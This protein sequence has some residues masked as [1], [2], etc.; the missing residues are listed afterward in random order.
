MDQMKKITKI[1]L[2][3]LLIFLICIMTSVIIIGSYVQTGDAM[4][5]MGFLPL[6][7]S[8]IPMIIVLNAK[9]RE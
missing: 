8:A 6:F 3:R 9:K 2:I 5:F 7:S 1:H 4:F